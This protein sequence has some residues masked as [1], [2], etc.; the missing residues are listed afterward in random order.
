TGSGYEISGKIAVAGGYYPVPDAKAFIYDPTANSWS[1]FPGLTHSTRNYGVAQLNG[2]LYA[3]GGYDYSNNTPSGA[4]YNQRYDATGP[5]P[6]PSNTPINSP[7]PTPTPFTTHYSVCSTTGASIDPGTTLVPGS[8]CGDCVN[9]ISLPF[10]YTLYDQTFT[11][12]KVAANGTLGF[13][14]AG[15]NLV[16]N[17]LPDLSANYAI[18]AYWD[19]LDL[20]SAGNGIYTSVTGTAPNRVLNVEWRSTRA[21]GTAVNFEI[22]LFEGQGQF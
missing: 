22:K 18:M 15:G 1:G 14:S 9:T 16:N 6:T 3:F 17:C 8:Q 12:A 19:D 4:N 5:T 13:L 7:T 21:G 10:P 2:F 11:T 20:S